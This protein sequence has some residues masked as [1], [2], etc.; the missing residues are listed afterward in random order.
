MSIILHHNKTNTLILTSPIKIHGLLYY[1]HCRVP[2]IKQVT[3]YLANKPE[4]EIKKFFDK[5]GIEG[6]IK[7]IKKQGRCLCIFMSK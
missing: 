6:G 2:N 1:Q 5:N 3:D 4:K 7:K